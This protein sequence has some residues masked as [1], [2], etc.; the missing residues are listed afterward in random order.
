MA[1]RMVPSRF[2]D[3]GEESDQT[4][5]PIKGYEKAS[6]VSLKEAVQPINSLL[7]DA[8]SMV[9]TARRNSRKP[10][11]GLTVDE[12]AAIHLY[13]MQWP[14]PHPSLYTTLNQRL[15]SKN[16]D[17]L[18]SWFLFLKLFFTAL[19]KLP[20]FKGTIWRGV[21]GNLNDQYDEDQIWWGASSCTETMKTMEA[22]VG[23]EDVRTIFTIECINGKAILNHS[24]FK[25]ENEIL[26]M[27]GSYFQVVD[28]WKPAKDLYMIHLREK[29]PPYETI[30]PPFEQSSPST[31]TL[32]IDKLTISKEKKSTS[33]GNITSAKSQGKFFHCSLFFV[34]CG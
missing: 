7:Y 12:S 30:A 20:S 25:E 1:E 2:L 26:L 21:R 19:Y 18:V 22:F 16:R 27:P 3:A 34:R 11:D 32:S 17:T 29:V 24:Y 28:K 33:T 14:E 8:D 5:A 31:K 23:L 4:L 13:T 10:A 9:E 15:R 6:L